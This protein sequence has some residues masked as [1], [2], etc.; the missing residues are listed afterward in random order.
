MR[1]KELSFALFSVLFRVSFVFSRQI[2]A[3]PLITSE[4]S[5]QKAAFRQKRRLLAVPAQSD[6]WAGLILMPR[7]SFSR[8]KL[9]FSNRQ[10]WC[11]PFSFSGQESRVKGGHFFP[12]WEYGFLGARAPRNG[13]GQFW[14]IQGALAYPR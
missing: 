14:P 11:I 4:G 12:I 3:A 5:A 13:S 7:M 8:E 2:Q 9:I 10:I 6:E 1:G